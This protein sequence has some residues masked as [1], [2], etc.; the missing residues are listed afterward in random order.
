MKKSINEIKNSLEGINSRLEEAAEWISSL[1]GRI[2]EIN[3][4]EQEREERL[5]KNENRL[6]KLSST[7]RYNNIYIIRITEKGGKW[8]A[9]YLFAIIII[10]I[11]AEN[12]TNLVKKTEIKKRKRKN[13]SQPR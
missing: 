7:T 10:I 5:I 13:K 3:Q 8:E 2:I 4:A 11:I 9:G 6:R 1:E 12:L